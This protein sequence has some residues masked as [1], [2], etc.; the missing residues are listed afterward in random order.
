MFYLTH[1]TMIMLA[2]NI[3]KKKKKKKRKRLHN[4]I[5]EIIAYNLT[6]FKALF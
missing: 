5:I 2:Y 6:M 4:V 3:L 1:K